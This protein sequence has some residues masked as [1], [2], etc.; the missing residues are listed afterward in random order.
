HDVLLVHAAGNDGANID[1]ECN[2]P[3]RYFVDS[4]GFN[5]GEADAWITVGATSWDKSDVIASF[6]NYGHKSVDV[7]APGVDIYSSVPSSEYKEQSGTS[8]AAPVVAGLA[9]LI[10]SYYPDFSAVEI[11]NIIM[12]SVVVIDDKVKVSDGGTSKKVLLSEIS[13]TGGIVNAYN[14]LKLA[15]SK[16]QGSKK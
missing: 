8:M 7:F 16:Y 12:E 5:Q 9:A 11:K 1:R 10:W 15:E 14:A 6:S 13:Q 3:N 4:L 2:Y